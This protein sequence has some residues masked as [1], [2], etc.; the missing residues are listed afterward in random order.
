MAAG[1]PQSTSSTVPVRDRT[2][3]LA[4][5]LAPEDV[6]LLADS[7]VDPDDFRRSTQTERLRLSTLPA[8]RTQTSSMRL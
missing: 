8:P 4:A 7:D 2:I 3:A 5:R 6:D 1:R